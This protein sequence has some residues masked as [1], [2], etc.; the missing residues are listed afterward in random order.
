MSEDHGGYLFV[1]TVLSRKFIG[2]LLG[3]VRERPMPD[4]MT[5]RGHTHDRSFVFRES[6]FGG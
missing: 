3:N 1:N 5:Q 2:H 6:E 4:V